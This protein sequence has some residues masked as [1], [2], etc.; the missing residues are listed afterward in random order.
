MIMRRYPARRS[1]SDSDMT[2]RL[3]HVR[4]AVVLT[5]IMASVVALT[6]YLLAEERAGEEPRQL[7]TVVSAHVVTKVDQGP[8]APGAAG[9]PGPGDRCLQFGST[10]DLG[11]AESVEVHTDQTTGRFV[12][13][14]KL[15][16]EDRDRFSL[17]TFASAGD[18]IAVSVQGRVVQEAKLESQL[19]GDHFVLLSFDTEA[20]ARDLADRLWA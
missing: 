11:R 15:A 12:V 1:G 10:F 7:L 3:A 14:V 20:E 17:W 13:D 16:A 2:Q 9:L 4:T 18:Q 8:C 5:L 19:P 6:F